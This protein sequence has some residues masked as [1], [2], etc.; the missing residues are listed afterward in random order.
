MTGGAPSS[1]SRMS[2]RSSDHSMRGARSG[3]ANANGGGGA[4]KAIASTRTLAMMLVLNANGLEETLCTL[5]LRERW[6]HHDTRQ[7]SPPHLL[8]YLQLIGE[9]GVLYRNAMAARS[10]YMDSHRGS[11]RLLVIWQNFVVVKKSSEQ[12]FEWIAF[13][14]NDNA[15][16]S[17][18]AGRLS[19]LRRLPEDVLENG[20][21]ISREES[22]RLKYSWEKLAV[23]SRGPALEEE[24]VIPCVCRN[25]IHEFDIIVLFPL[26]LLLS[27]WH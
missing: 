3:S 4:S 18:L 19:M 24:G 13:R 27:P 10:Y 21:D 15:M 17:S 6:T 2:S 7:L 16:V 12:G 26:S 14:T 8:S 20:Y 23:F 11:A 25:S 22:R 1:R 5:R 9:R